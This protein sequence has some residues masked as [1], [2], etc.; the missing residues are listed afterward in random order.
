MSTLLIH[1]VIINCFKHFLTIIS[2]GS[3]SFK[4]GLCSFMYFSFIR[5]SHRW[6]QGCW[7]LRVWAEVNWDCARHCW[8]DCHLSLWRLVFCGMGYYEQIWLPIFLDL[9][10]YTNHWKATTFGFPFFI[11]VCEVLWAWGMTQILTLRVFLILC[12][13]A[14]CNTGNFKKINKRFFFF[15]KKKKRME[16]RKSDTH[17]SWRRWPYSQWLTS[18]P[19]L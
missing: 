14:C 1:V 15:K 10:T 13:L 11:Q 4:Y 16:R 19:S 18:Q 8:L 2:S 9:K 6:C 17:A 12:S 3:L 7:I 5:A